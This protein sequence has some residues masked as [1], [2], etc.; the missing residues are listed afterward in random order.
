[1]TRLMKPNRAVVQILKELQKLEIENI[2]FRHKTPSRNGACSVFDILLLKSVDVEA[3][4][5]LLVSFYYI[6]GYS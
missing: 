3:V 6:S 4:Q 1:M 5:Q 2:L